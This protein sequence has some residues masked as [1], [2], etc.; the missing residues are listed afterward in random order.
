MRPIT[1]M[2]STIKPNNSGKKGPRPESSCGEISYFCEKR[3]YLQLGDDCI[4]FGSVR[5]EQRSL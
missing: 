2:K 1:S 5:K 4:F 3:V